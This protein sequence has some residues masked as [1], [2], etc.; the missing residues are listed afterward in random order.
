[1]K[2]TRR[3]L[4]RIIKEEVGKTLNEVSSSFH[5]RDDVSEEIH[6][7]WGDVHPTVMR[8]IDEDQAWSTNEEKIITWVDDITKKLWTASQNENDII[9]GLI[10][11]AGQMRADSNK[12]RDID[13]VR[14]GINVIVH[15]LVGGWHW[16]AFMS[17][18]LDKSEGNRLR[19]ILIRNLE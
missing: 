16:S 4:K 11:I 15:I 14:E 10:L 19:A 8:V 2:I 9:A 13:T 3:Q 1:M 5:G 17:G 18:S 12:L 6:E 7:W